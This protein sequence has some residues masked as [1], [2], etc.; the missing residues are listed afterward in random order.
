MLAG[1]MLQSLYDVLQGIPPFGLYGETSQ[2]IDGL[3]ALLTGIALDNSQLSSLASSV[4]VF[5][6]GPSCIHT[7]QSI[8]ALAVALGDASLIMRTSLLLSQTSSH[9]FMNSLVKIPKVSSLNINIS[10]R[11]QTLQ[12]LLAFNNEISLSIFGPAKQSLSSIGDFTQTIVDAY[13]P[14]GLNLEKDELV[15][16]S[17]AQTNAY[18]FIQSDR[19]IIK[20]GTGANGTARRVY[21]QVEVINQHATQPS[22]GFVNSRLLRR[23]SSDEP[24]TF[25]ELSTMTLQPIAT[26]RVSSE[27]KIGNSTSLVFFDGIHVGALSQTQNGM[28][29]FIQ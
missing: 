16:V 11:P 4:S 1:H 5:G 21:H 12:N 8:T 28:A 25:E 15:Y 14:E 10:F 9:G 27:S 23:F 6:G 22:I 18:V 3:R 7:I 26:I 2:Q 13:I 17:I 29:I 24:G 19:R 20:I